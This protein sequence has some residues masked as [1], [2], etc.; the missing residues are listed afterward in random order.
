MKLSTEHVQGIHPDLALFSGKVCNLSQKIKETTALWES[1]MAM[2]I[3]D[4]PGG[5]CGKCSSSNGG[6]SITVSW[7]Q[8]I[9]GLKDCFG[10]KAHAILQLWAPTD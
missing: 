10:G 8:W 1:N 9:A 5:P 2:E 6:L 7:L 3:Q 4:N